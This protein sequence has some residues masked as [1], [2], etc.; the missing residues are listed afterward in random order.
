MQSPQIRA[1]TGL[2]GLAA[3]FVVVY[4]ESDKRGAGLSYNLLRHGYNAVDLFFIL[5][6]FVMALTYGRDFHHKSDFQTYLSF[7]GK[8][9]ARVYPL[10]FIATLS[11]F[12]IYSMHL[13]HNE[14]SSSPHLQL[15]L[16]LLGV[17]AWGLADSIVGP[18]WSIST[19]WAAYLLFPL[20]AYFTLGASRANAW[21]ICVVSWLSLTV[22]A[23]APGYIVGLPD[24][25]SGPLDIFEHDSI[26]PLVRCLAGFSLGLLAYRWRAHSPTKHAT[27]L[28][29][30]L[31]AALIVPGSDL[32]LI[33]VCVFLIP[34]LS[35]DEGFAARCMGSRPV[36][37][38]GMWSYSIYILHARF[39]PIRVGFE[40]LCTKAHLSRPTV[41]AVV[42]SVAT[43]ILCSAVTYN[44][45]EKPMRRALR[46]LFSLGRSMPGR[47]EP[48]T[49]E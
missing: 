1:L 14:L 17:Q 45:V 29:L 46:G 5:S 41:V 18:A 36:L 38:L 4:H 6:G 47:R 39:N 37:A 32:A 9:I 26:A 28:A 22:I 25:R 8:R 21:A 24:T 40:T 48:A 11:T 19:E 7:L 15:V 43:L 44:V 13:S 2:R 12:V 49:T 31:V 16:N 34:A 3:I 33:L 10:Y 42:L 20:L 30:T 35:A 27:L 23:Y